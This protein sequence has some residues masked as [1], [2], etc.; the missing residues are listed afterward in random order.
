MEIICPKCQIGFLYSSRQ[1]K[2]K[3]CSLSCANKSNKATLVEIDLPK[4]SVKLAEFMG[5][6]LGDGCASNYYSTVSLNS[7]ADKAYVPYV[8]HLID[9][10]FVGGS[11][12]AKQIKNVNLVLIQI[13]SVQISQFLRNEGLLPNNK[14][15]PAWIL[16]NQTYRRACVRGLFDT[17]GSISYKF[18]KSKKGLSIYKQLNFRNADQKLMHFV[19]Q[20]LLDLGLKPTM[21]QTRSLYL[22]NHEDIDI[23]STFIGFS[24]PKLI[25]RS[26]VKDQES[27]NAWQRNRIYIET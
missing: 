21:S 15:I 18:Y 5:I 8:L 23:Y 24:N 25:Q 10:L 14:K 13:S 4:P 16:E 27:Y 9:K 22:S 12:N 2:K 11:F 1:R 17:E 26:L 19:R 20:E 6:M 3:F 7:H